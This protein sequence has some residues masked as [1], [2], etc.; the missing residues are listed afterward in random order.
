MNFSKINKIIDMSRGRPCSE[1]L[2]LSLPMVSNFDNLDFL[3]SDGIDCKNYG[4]LEGIFECRKLFG[5]L[6]NLKPENVLIFGNSSLSIMYELISQSVLFG[7]DGNLPWSQMK[8]VKW[9]CPVPG[10]DR[11]FRITEHF[12]IE[13]INVPMNCNGPDMDLIEEF[14]KDPLVKGI[15]C[16]PK[17]S[18]PTGIT[19]SDEVV[20]RFAKLKPAAKDFR[21]YWDEAYCTHNLYKDSDEKLLEI[22]DLSKKYNNEDMIYKFFST[23]KITFPGSGVAALGASVKNLEAIKEHLKVRTICFDKMNQFR[24]YN[25]L[26]TKQGVLNHMQKHADIIRPKFEYIEKRLSEVEKCCSFTKPLGGY[27]IY[28]IVNNKAKEIIQN[29]REKGL[30]LTDAGCSFPYHKDP[31]NSGIRIAPTCIKFDE[32]KEAMDILISVINSVC[33]KIK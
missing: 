29:C 21:I 10:Y 31:K 14:V 2:E 9:L 15:W 32:L 5:E 11:H 19:Y 27:F 12:E 28:L 3:T 8:K 22:Y 33:S 26:K 18:N 25:F 13:M 17:Y 24:H 30:I 1:Q 16:V 23:S 4:T 7:I 6:L 20:E